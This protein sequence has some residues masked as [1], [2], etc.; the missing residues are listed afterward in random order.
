MSRTR[1]N[2]ELPTDYYRQLKSIADQEGTTIAELLRRATKL[3]LFV[4]SIKDDPSARLLVDR[5]GEIQE[6]IVDLI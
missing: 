5:G 2:L 3:L 1:Y 4:Q 6:I